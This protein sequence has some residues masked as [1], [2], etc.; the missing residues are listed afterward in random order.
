[1]SGGLIAFAYRLRAL[2]LNGWHAVLVILDHFAFELFDAIRMV[3]ILTTLVVFDRCV[4]PN[5]SP[6]CLSRV[7]FTVYVKCMVMQH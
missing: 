4:A 3:P 2:A 7:E 5:P 1:M 6:I